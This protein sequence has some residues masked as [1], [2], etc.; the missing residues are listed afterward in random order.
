MKKNM[1]VKKIC[2]LVNSVEMLKAHEEVLTVASRKPGGK[3]YHGV[4]EQLAY[5]MLKTA[6][7]CQDIYDEVVAL[8]TAPDRIKEYETKK[9]ETAN[10]FA[11]KDEKGNPLSADL[12][13]G[14]MEFDMEDA[15]GFNTAVAALDL[16]YA[17]DLKWRDQSRKAVR[18]L[19]KETR[20]VEVHMV[21]AA[22]VPKR[23]PIA[24][25][26]ALEPMIEEPVEAPPAPVKK[27]GE[28][29]AVEVKE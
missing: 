18:E 1:T 22:F 14:R 15:D 20:E 9:T 16:E 2:G 3:P 19:L 13:G 7:K 4:E 11:R 5:G 12:G 26:Q 25:R 8:E 27:E 23:L 21:A 24:I 28:K 6:A 10:K 17:N 29:A